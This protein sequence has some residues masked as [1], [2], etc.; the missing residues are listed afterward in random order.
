MLRP[1]TLAQLRKRIDGRPV[2]VL[3]AGPDRGH[4]LI[5]PARPGEPVVHVPLPAPTRAEVV[6]QVETLMSACHGDADTRMSEIRGGGLHLADGQTLSA[7]HLQGVRT[8]NGDLAFLSACDTA[9]PHPSV[10][11]EPLH[12]TAA[13]LLAG[14]RAVVGTLWTALDTAYLARAVY[15]DLTHEG[16]QQADT[17]R[18]AEALNRAV[19]DLLDRYPAVPTRRAGHLHTGP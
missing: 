7:S 19:R 1:P 14:F 9:R 13:F 17:T 11:D 15:A 12:M 8:D 10:P 6:R 3:V 18:V 5:V 16:Q 2:I 4:A